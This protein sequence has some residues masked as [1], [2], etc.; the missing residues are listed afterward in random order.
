MQSRCIFVAYSITNNFYVTP[1]ILTD[2]FN[3]HWRHSFMVL[4]FI[5]YWCFN[6]HH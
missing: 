3:Y 5:C 1:Y 6:P 4:A 2:Q